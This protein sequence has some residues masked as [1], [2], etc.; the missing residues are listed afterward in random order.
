MFTYETQTIAAAGKDMA[1]IEL[2]TYWLKKTE[3]PVT[4]L[5]SLLC[6]FHF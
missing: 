5:P 6:F 4:R 3:V 2:L 1:A